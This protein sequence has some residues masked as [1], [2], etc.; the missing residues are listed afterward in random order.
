M[1]FFYLDRFW[2]V[3]ST[4]ENVNLGTFALMSLQT[5]WEWKNRVLLEEHSIFNEAIPPEDEFGTNR[6]RALDKTTAT[7]DSTLLIGFS[8]S[9]L[10][11]LLLPRFTAPPRGSR[12]LPDG[13][14][15]KPNCN[16]GLESRT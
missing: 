2:R 10:G 1:T 6:R 12:G 5:L 11:T 7:G 3:R 14:R 16:V 15:S 13:F 8:I 4:Y 9:G